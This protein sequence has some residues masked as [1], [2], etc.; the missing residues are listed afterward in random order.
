MII[1]VP[2]DLGA[3]NL[4]V[5][6]GPKAFRNSQ[7]I[8]KL[9]GAGLLTKDGGDIV[10]ADRSSLNE[11]DKKL[12]Y[13]DEILRVSEELAGKTSEVVKSGGAP[14]ALGGDHSVCLG[15]VAGASVALNGNLGL[16]YL[17]AHGDLNTTETS[18]TGNI[19]GM[20]LAALLG[21]GEPQLVSVHGPGAKLQPG[22]LLLVGGSDYDQAELDLVRRERIDSF[23][24]LDL[25]TSGLAPLLGKIDKLAKKVDNVWVSLDLDCI[26]QLYAPAAGMP[27]AGGLTYREITAIAE[28]IA[29][30]CH[31]V[32]VDVVEYNPPTDQENKTAELTT[33]LIAALFGAKYSWYTNYLKRN[34]A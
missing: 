23:S 21:H 11:G 1:G 22:N 34:Q 3:Q 31:V 10:P 5:S 18:P 8:T 6:S 33:Q 32:G 27:N 26:D 15:A 25:L 9:N 19:H 13:L 28:Y 24:M 29:K 7:L 16:I 4:G 30:T 2:M 12:R 17:D 14:V 20:H